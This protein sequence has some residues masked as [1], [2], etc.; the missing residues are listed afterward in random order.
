MKMK[1]IILASSSI[2]RKQQLER[3]SISFTTI[4]PDV[5]EEDSKAKGLDHVQL[6][7]ELSLLKTRDISRLYDDAVV[8]GGDTIAS[9]NGIILSKPKTKEKSFEQL[10]ILV[11][12][13]HK[14]ITSTTISA[15][16]KEHIHTCTANMKMRELTDEQILRYIEI[17]KPLNSCGSYRLDKLGISLFESIDCE[18]YTAI[19]GIPLMWTAKTLT[20]IG[21]SI[22]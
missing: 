11:G 21:L 2:Y 18:D 14:L 6:S 1:K 22:P 3:L 5:N 13:E 19:I 12:K 17:D 10:K 20:E 7:R 9:F 16:G 8:I 15:Y 4:S